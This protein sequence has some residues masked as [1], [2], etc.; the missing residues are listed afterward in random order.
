MV[1]PIHSVEPEF[2]VEDQNPAED[3]FAP[4]SEDNPQAVAAE[5]DWVGSAPTD[6]DAMLAPAPDLSSLRRVPKRSAEHKKLLAGLQFKQVLIPVL[7][8]VG[9][10]SLVLG[11]CKYLLGP[12][13]PFAYLPD[14]VSW[15]SF[16]LGAALLAAAVVVIL[17][18]KALLQHP[19]LSE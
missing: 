13:S 19:E 16:G 2:I 11:S 6:D 10:L 12:D 17:S 3:G 18:V 7:L 8:T 1:R 9:M 4:T 5:G 14:W 15:L